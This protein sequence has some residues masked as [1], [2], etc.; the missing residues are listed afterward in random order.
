MMT[1]QEALEMV[2]DELFDD[3][4]RIEERL[5][6]ARTMCLEEAKEI[7]DSLNEHYSLDGRQTPEEFKAEQVAF[8][9]GKLEHSL[10]MH[11]LVQG[12]LT[13]VRE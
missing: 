6:A 5:V 1:A 2:M 13:R 7:A 9:Q 4:K 8:M 3:R 11:T 12:F 10:D